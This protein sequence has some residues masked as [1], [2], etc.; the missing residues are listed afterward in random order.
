MGSTNLDPALGFSLAAASFAALWV[1]HEAAGRDRTDV[2]LGLWCVE[3]NPNLYLKPTHLDDLTAT[4]RSAAP[5]PQDY[6][7]VRISGTD[8]VT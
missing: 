5:P 6:V 3:A 2:G 4:L 1:L 7:P 8:Q